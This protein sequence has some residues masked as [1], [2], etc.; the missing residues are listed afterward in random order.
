[1]RV[2]A[3]RFTR[4]DTNSRL[5][6]ILNE[7]VPRVSTSWR[8]DSRTR[9]AS[10]GFVFSDDQGRKTRNFEIGTLEPGLGRRNCTL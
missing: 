1:M 10:C 8:E 9:V 4:T 2:V 7:R 6:I 5:A 3:I